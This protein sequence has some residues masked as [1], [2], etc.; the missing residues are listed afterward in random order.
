M[1]FQLKN[2][3]NELLRWLG[4]RAVCLSEIATAVTRQKEMHYPGVGSDR[5]SVLCGASVKWSL[6]WRNRI[7]SISEAM[8]TSGTGT[9]THE[10]QNWK[11]ALFLLTKILQILNKNV[12]CLTPV[13]ISI[14]HTKVD[15]S[16]D[17]FSI[18]I[19]N[20][21]TFC[22]TFFLSFSFPLLSLFS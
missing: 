11:S 16:S 12:T 22:F 19:S 15:W 6:D 17:S 14:I 1:S 5:M 10:K 21:L 4:S 20:T 9:K 8:W 18:R 7:L 13:H 3:S 2:K